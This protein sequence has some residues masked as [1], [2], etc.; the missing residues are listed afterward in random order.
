MSHAGRFV[1]R[2]LVTPKP[3]DSAQ[4]Y[5]QLFGWSCK[6]VDMG[7]PEPYQMLRNDALDEDVAGATGIPAPG[8]PPHWL[9]Y[10]TV[11]DVDAAAAKVEGL[12][13]TLLSE[14]MDIPGVG[15]FA[16]AADPGGAVLAVFTS[17]TPGASDTDRRPPVGTFCWSQLMS[18]NLDAVASFY[19]NVFGWTA[20][21]RED[22]SVWFMDGDAPRASAMP[23]PDD[24][25]APD[26]WLKYVAT[27]DTDGSFARAQELGATPMVPPTD[28][29]GMGRFAVLTDPAGAAFALWTDAQG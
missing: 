23:K 20:V 16:T 25:Q 7:M 1:W 11:D 2:E 17:R 14:P 28:I 19:S 13:G 6:P 3:A 10:I 15:R 26:H 18:G 4:F 29:P 12:G 21:A 5:G 24:M 27:D 8:I 9:D 22:G